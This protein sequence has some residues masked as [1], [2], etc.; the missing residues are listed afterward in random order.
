MTTLHE[1]KARL[2]RVLDRKGR[3]YGLDSFQGAVRAD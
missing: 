3:G 2:F 1:A